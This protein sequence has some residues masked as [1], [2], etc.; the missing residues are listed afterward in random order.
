MTSRFETIVLAVILL[1]ISV[2]IVCFWT[3]MPWDLLDIYG[4]GNGS[5]AATFRE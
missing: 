1:M 5:P 3:G 4:T 2:L